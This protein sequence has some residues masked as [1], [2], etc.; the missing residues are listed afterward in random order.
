MISAAPHRSAESG[1]CRVPE[2]LVMATSGQVTR[3]IFDRYNIV[4]KSDLMD[5]AGELDQYL[6]PNSG[7]RTRMLGARMG[8]EQK[9][10]A[11]PGIE[12]GFPD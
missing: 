8:K 10:V 5:A 6:S 3:A 12:P 9:L 7:H 11:V 2:R 4:N 1:A